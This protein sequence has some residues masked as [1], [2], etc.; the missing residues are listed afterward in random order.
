MLKDYISNFNVYYSIEF[1][2]G[3]GHK[4]DLETSKTNSFIIPTLICKV[5]RIKGYT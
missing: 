5:R 3:F 2:P 1:N 4:L